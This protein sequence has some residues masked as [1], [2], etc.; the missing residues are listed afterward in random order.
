M[1]WV[2]GA[3]GGT[4]SSAAGTDSAADYHPAWTPDGDLVFSTDRGGSAEVWL[5]HDDSGEEGVVVAGDH[6]VQDADL[7]PCGDWLAFRVDLEEGQ[8]IGVRSLDGGTVAE[9]PVPDGVADASD[10]AWR[11]QPCQA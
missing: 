5:H 11:S 8:R 2:V 10:P 4:A 7:S 1:V 3:D 6:P 9:L